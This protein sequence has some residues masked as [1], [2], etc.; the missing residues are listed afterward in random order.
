MENEKEKVKVKKKGKNGLFTLFACIMTAIIVV[1]AM[2]IG[3]KLSKMVE[4]N[5]AS[6]STSNTNKKEMISALIFDEN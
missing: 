5:K 1:L 4:N 3:D 2:N 6:N